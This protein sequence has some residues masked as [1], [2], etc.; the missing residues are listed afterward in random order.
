MIFAGIEDRR[1]EDPV[2]ARCRVR[3]VS[4]SGFST[5]V[6]RPPSGTTTR[7]ETLVAHIREVHAERTGR[8]GSPRLAIEWNERGLTCCVHT[9]AKPVAENVL[10]RDFTPATPNA[11][12]GADITDIPT[13][14][15]WVFLALVVDLF[16]RRIVG[17]SMA[18]PRTSRLGVDALNRA[19]NRRGPPTGLVA[20]SDRGSP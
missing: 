20:H 8:Y 16:S 4:R 5:R 19:V 10:D 7:R 6:Q 12:W 15:G 14:E 18:A 9:V 1:V 11:T 13:L 2:A 17:G 3:G